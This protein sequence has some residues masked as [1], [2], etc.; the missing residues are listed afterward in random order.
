MSSFQQAVVRLNSLFVLSALVLLLQTSGAR[1]GC[2]DSDG[3]HCY[4]NT[5]I[6][7]GVVWSGNG[8]YAVGQLKSANATS[9]LVVLHLNKEGQLE[10]NPIAVPLPP[11]TQ[12]SQDKPTIGESRKVLG[13]PDGSIIVLGL[14]TF[15]DETQVPWAFRIAANGAI[16]WNKAFAAEPGVVTIFHSG[17]FDRANDRLIIVGRRTSGSDDGQCKNWSQSYL[18]ALKASS[19]QIEFPAQYFGTPAPGVN[20]RQAFQ[21]ISSA[22]KPNSYVVTGFASGPNSAK[23]GEC[24]DNIIVQSFSLLPQ[25]L[26]GQNWT[27]LG[28]NKIGATD[29]NEM[30]YSIRRMSPGSYLIAGYGKDPAKGVPAAQAFRVKLAPA[31][32]VEA[33][34][35]S[36]FPA[37]GSDKDGGDRFRA[38]VALS[39]KERFIFV[40]SGS[41]GKKGANQ[42]IWEI[43]QGD[44]KRPSGLYQFTSQIGSDILDA[45]LSSSGKVL[46]VGK[47]VDDDHQV[48][49]WAGYLPTTESAV[50]APKTTPLDVGL[51]AVTSLP[52]VGDS[53][54]LP[55][56]AIQSGQA[57]LGKDLRAGNQ[58]N[59]AFSV[60]AP[61]TLK[62]SIR[63][64]AGDPDL[65]LLDRDKR[66]IAFSN[67][68]R[69]ATEIVIAM[70]APGE[71]TISIIGIVDV[72][73]YEVRLEPFA[74]NDSFAI[75]QKLGDEQ[76]K[77]LTGTLTSLGYACSPE[78]NIAFGSETIR[79]IY[80]ARQSA[81]DSRPISLASIDPLVKP[82]AK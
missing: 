48:S 77:K 18:I 47:W 71:Y 38:V 6:I 54:Q 28:S 26:S 49:G 81:G 32:S 15:G 68:P 24:Q 79:S 7:A 21:D 58:V 22:E 40:G 5:G 27:L 8:F 34:L 39:D 64:D 37:D 3:V 53:Y 2:G 36:P 41:N 78:T 52:V 72:R 33:S 44:L 60:A 9:G 17:I 65:V 31:F 12:T 19:G 66:P 82:Q 69:A 74:D 51:A 1:A 73:S 61:R 55:P 70:L 11:N 76:R 42:A 46:G 80:A 45:A 20:N 14:L 75:V 13:L 30:A 25:A 63:P 43:V 59:L 67:F 16:L 29:T 57:Y 50:S 35:S 23:A 62:I 10:D 56:A 4:P